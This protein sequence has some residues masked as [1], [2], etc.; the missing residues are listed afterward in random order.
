MKPLGGLEPGK[1]SLA[2]GIWKWFLL[3]GR[4]GR[5]RFLARVSPAALGWGWVRGQ[6]LGVQRGRDGRA[7][8][9]VG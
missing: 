1:Q 7:G 3:C 2:Q 4:K 9:E 5:G 6:P 8:K